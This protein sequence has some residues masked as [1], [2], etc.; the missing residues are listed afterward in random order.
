MNDTGKMNVVRSHGTAVCTVFTCKYTK[1]LF[2]SSYVQCLEV[3]E[4]LFV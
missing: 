4:E 3:L 1:C 2:S